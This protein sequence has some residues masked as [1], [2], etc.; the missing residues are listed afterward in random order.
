[1]K[2]ITKQQAHRIERRLTRLYGERSGALLE[3]FYMLLGRYGVGEG[4][5]PVRA[6]WDE[7]DVVLI[8]YAD[9]LR[10][11]EEE[12]PLRTL[13]RFC[14]EHLRKSVSCIHLLPFFPW[15]SDDGFSVID[16]RRVAPANGSWADVGR[17]GKD[18]ELMFD[19]VLNHCSRESAWFRDY[20][21]GIAPARFYF[22]PTDPASDLSAVVRPRPWPLL[23][24]VHTREGR[25]HLWTTFSADQVDLNWANPDVL[26]EFLDILFRYL[27][28][29]CRFFRLD[30]VAFL[31]KRI[32]TPC[33]HL[34]ETHEVVR[35]FRDVLDVVA[36]DA[37][38][39]TET[40]VPHEENLSYFG[41]GN[42]AHM[43]YNFALPP[44]LLHA[45]LRGDGRHLA[46]WAA[47]LPEL[48]PRQAFFNFTASHDGIGVR[49][50]QG[51][52]E[53]GEIEWLVEAIRA[54]GGEVS[55]RA[56]PD[57]TERP[58]ELNCT[59]RD[60]LAVPGD[61]ELSIAR[62][63]CSQ[64]VML[65]FKGMPAVYVQSLLGTSNWR[66]GYAETGEKRTLNRRVWAADELEARLRAPE[67]AQARVFA[68]YKQWL[69]RRRGHPAF[70]PDAA[71]EVREVGAALF[72]FVRIA[73]SG[74]ERIVCLFNLS[75]E[76]REVA[77]SPLDPSL[78]AAGTVRD[79]LSAR[80]LRLDRQG[81]LPLAPC[82]AYWLTA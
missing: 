58:Y 6:L 16:Y 73:P 26:F 46:A 27:A 71:Q 75:T 4:D 11:A 42:E 10:G 76:R 19:L 64:A 1:M 61:E 22:L 33:I 15:S 21:T 20:V 9:T 28:E 14:A 40:N 34:P 52:L 17:L 45:L 54:R 37:V 57:G 18:F 32:G 50:L 67:G 82:H 30:A 8:T 5:R 56:V 72:C 55:M 44:L 29:G 39:I 23:T 3:R 13:H 49:P 77:L 69:V 24:E 65:A 43:V 7:N 47:S 31:W 78:P 81:R 25:A 35:L 2:F 70:H 36:P 62:F 66:E 74:D 38:L 59:Y 51:L 41:K 68:R 60:A 12:A 53:H 80:R 48:G 79:L 63:L